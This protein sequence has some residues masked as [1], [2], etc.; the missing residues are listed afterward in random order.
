MIRLEPARSGQ[1]SPRRARHRRSPRRILRPAHTELAAQH[2]LQ[3]EEFWRKFKI[4]QHKDYISLR[5][6]QI[7]IRE[8]EV[9]TQREWQAIGIRV[10]DVL[11][12]LANKICN[13]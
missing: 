4:E 11:D 1:T 3:A 10:L 8:M 13:D 6:E 9:Q 7:R 5:R 12:K 2:F